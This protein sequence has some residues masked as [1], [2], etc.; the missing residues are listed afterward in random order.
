V[1]E[2]ILLIDDDRVPIHY[3]LRALGE[4][5]HAVEHK[6]NPDEAIE[7]LDMKADE[8]DL[9]ILD[10]MIP[11]G[12]AFA[13]EKTDEGM[14]SG[15]FLLKKI[16]AQ[17]PT[18]PVL[19]LTNLSP[20]ELGGDKLTPLGQVESARKIDTD[21]FDLVDRVRLLLDSRDK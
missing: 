8:V 19:I 3:Y 16:R 14:T 9:I 12:K 18:L 11:S 1:N 5:G 2:R 15:L 21:P 10:V 6:R 20:S 13:T 17:W 4:A 7:Y